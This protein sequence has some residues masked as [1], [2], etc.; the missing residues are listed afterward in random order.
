M[1]LLLLLLAAGEHLLDMAERSSPSATKPS[2]CIC[3]RG[4][5]GTLVDSG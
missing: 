5:R 1:L 3:V 2:L 4:I